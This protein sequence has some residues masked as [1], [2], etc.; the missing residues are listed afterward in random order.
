ML[1]A[2]KTQ[3]GGLR[4]LLRAMSGMAPPPAPPALMPTPTAAEAAATAGA[5]SA[6]AAA[7][8]PA[9]PSSAGLLPL[10]FGLRFA[11][12]R[13]YPDIRALREDVRRAAVEAANAG[14]AA[15]G[16]RPVAAHRLYAEASRPR[17]W[18][19]G[20][21]FASAQLEKK[22]GLRAV[23]AALVALGNG[24]GGGRGGGS[25][26]GGGGGGGGEAL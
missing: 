10:P 15:A 13:D 8:A 6:A 11:S 23:H 1:A 5:P 3:P 16:L 4:S 9:A 12:A 17:W 7:A 22:G 14:R 24:D 25:G 20:V 19:G 2:A 21:A 18:P 26:G